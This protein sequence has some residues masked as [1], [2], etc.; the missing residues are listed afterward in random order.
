MRSM[1]EYSSNK[2]FAPFLDVR[3]ASLGRI[4]EPVKV[5]PPFNSQPHL[6]VKCGNPDTSRG[7]QGLHLSIPWPGRSLRH[8]VLASCGSTFVHEIFVLRV[9]VCRSLCCW[10][11]RLAVHGAVSDSERH[12]ARPTTP[13]C[14][15]MSRSLP[16]SYRRQTCC[17][18]HKPGG[19]C[20]SCVVMA[21]SNAAPDM[22]LN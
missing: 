9:S 20:A 2:V 18:V 21:C 19:T 4:A 17:S 10:P 8:R 14:R 5:V 6:F 1:D 22:L 7:L 3:R 15:F 11:L 13:C 12:K 16:S